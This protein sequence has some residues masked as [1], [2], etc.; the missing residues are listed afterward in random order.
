MTAGAGQQ[1]QQAQG[2]SDSGRR[3]TVTV[4]AIHI[5]FQMNLK[6]INK[7]LILARKHLSMG[8]MRVTGSNREF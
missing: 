3:V 7:A 1:R 5:D 6:C 4:G 2:N 8:V